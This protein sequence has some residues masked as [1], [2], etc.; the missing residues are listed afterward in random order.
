MVSLINHTGCRVTLVKPCSSPL[1]T[2]FFVGAESLLVHLSRV[3]SG[4]ETVNN[5][6]AVQVL[7]QLHQV[8]GVHNIGEREKVDM[9]ITV[10][11]PF[12]EDIRWRDSRFG[13]I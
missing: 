13:V 10:K 4:E 6:F 9:G 5:I 2:H 12:R 1:E 7:Y 8:N 11:L 3:S